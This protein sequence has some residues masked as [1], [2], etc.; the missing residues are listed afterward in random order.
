ML[1]CGLYS[2][3]ELDEA[4]AKEQKEREDETKRL[5]ATS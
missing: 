5:E 1:R 2:L 3:D 4:K